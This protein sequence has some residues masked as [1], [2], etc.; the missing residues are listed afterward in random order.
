MDL[1]LRPLRLDDEAEFWAAHEELRAEGFTFGFIREDESFAEHVDRLERQRRGHDLGDLV[2]ATWLVAEVD[3]AMVGRTS[4]RHRLNDFLR[5]FGGHIGYGVRPACR[6]R[7]YAT[8][9]LR[10]S[11]VIARSYGID[12][13]LVMC[14]DDNVASA[15]VIEARGGHW[16]ASSPSTSTASPCR[17]AATGSPDRPPDPASRTE[18]IASERATRVLRRPER[19]WTSDRAC[20]PTLLVLAARARVAIGARAGEPL[21]RR[22]VSR[23]PRRGRPP[24]R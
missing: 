20:A 14:D 23:R 10:Q 7:G 6:R 1:R 4:V 12:R 13:V 16:R 19:K 2:E 9:I 24:A 8:E 5:S 21:R 17:S 18:V 22:T 3:G 11:L 15:A